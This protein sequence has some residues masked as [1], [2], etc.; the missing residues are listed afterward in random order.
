MSRTERLLDLLQILRRNR[1]PVS[2]ATIASELG[3]SLRTLY[4]DIVTLQAQGAQI[5]GEPGVGYRLRPCFMLPPLMFSEEE[6]EA[7]VLGSRWVAKKTD[8]RLALSS[9]N[10]LAKISAVLPEDLRNKLETAG[11]L[12]GPGHEIPTGDKE[13]VLIRQAIRFEQKIEITYIDLKD[14]ETARVIWPFAVVF[15]DQVR[16][17]AAWCEVR[18]EFRHFR[19]DRIKKLTL[20]N[21]RYPKRRHTLQKEWR[22]LQGIPLQ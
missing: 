4:R 7:L 9:R 21:L 11:L 16:I 3:I 20:M 19:I 10:A 15:F 12:V 14:N 17:L 8:S 13:Q 18:Q 1:Y 22:E 6:I 2:G 5:D